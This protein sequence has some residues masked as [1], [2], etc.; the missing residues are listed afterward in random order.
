M[1]FGQDDYVKKS[2]LTMY[3]KCFIFNEFAS[4]TSVPRNVLIATKAHQGNSEG[5]LRLFVKMHHSGFEFDH[6]SF[7][8][9]LAGSNLATLEEGQ[10]IHSSIIKLGFASDQH[11]ANAAT[12][13]YGK[14][15]DT[16][17]VLKILPQP[18]NR[19]M[20]SWN[21]L[22]SGFSRHVYCKEAIETFNEIDQIGEWPEHVT[23]VSLLSACNHGG[24]IDEGLSYICSM[25]SEFG[26]TQGIHH[27][28]CIIDLLGLSG[29][30]SEAEKF[31]TEMPVSPNDLIWRSK[32]VL[33]SYRH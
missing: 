23:F 8:G 21:I 18:I 6:F 30:L 29:W 25:M 16:I 9:A 5:A 3:A 24:V 14:C 17:D 7:S 26:V 15:G 1:G 12:D 19:S 33:P 32:E 4:K 22:I 10:Q 28:V 13:V 11:A 27:C 31:I 2:L 20:L